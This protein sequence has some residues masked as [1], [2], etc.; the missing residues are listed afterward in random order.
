MKSQKLTLKVWSRW[1]DGVMESMWGGFGE[2]VR[3][4]T[5]S[6]VWTQAELVEVQGLR[7]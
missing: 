3:S 7:S 6:S 2:R 4:L 1:C 5:R